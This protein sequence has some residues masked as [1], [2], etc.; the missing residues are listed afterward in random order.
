MSDAE[1]R[2]E[3]NKHEKEKKK[4]EF[5]K[6]LGVSE[7]RSHV[8]PLVR[9]ALEHG[10][11]PEKIYST[12]IKSGHDADEVKSALNRNLRKKED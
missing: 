11:K 6:K 3:I 9:T 1:I 8:E 5:H 12:L 4:R 10:E 7:K 2:D